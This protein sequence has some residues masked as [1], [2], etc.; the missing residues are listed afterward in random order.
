[1]RFFISLIL[2]MVFSFL[3]ELVMPWWSIAIVAFAV[4]Y[5][6]SLRPGIA[7]LSGFLSIAIFWLLVILIRD[8]ANAHILST[9]MAALFNLPG[10]PLFILLALVVGGL[11]GGL[12]AWAGALYGTRRQD[13]TLV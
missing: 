9:R 13:K 5:F 2:I 6:Y 10:Y 7:F 11:V 1:M 4:C 3:A 12:A 8:N